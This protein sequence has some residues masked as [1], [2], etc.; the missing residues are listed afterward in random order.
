M[1]RENK[2]QAAPVDVEF[3]RSELESHWIPF[4]DNKSFKDDPRL[5]VKGEGVYLWNQR[6]ERLLDGSSGLFTTAAGHCRP[7]ITKA[8]A[9]QLAELDYIPS[10]LR[11]HPR[12]FELSNKLCPILP[13]PMNHVFFCNS[14]S[15]AVDSAIKIILQYHACRGEG[16]RNIFVSRHRAYHGVNIG[17][18]SLSGLVKNRTGFNGMMPGVV[19]MRSTW[20]EEQ[21]FSRG[22]PLHRGVELADDLLR[23]VQTHG[24]KSIAAVFVEPIAGSTGVLVPPVG[25]LERIREIC[26]EHNIIMVIDEVLTGFGRTGAAFASNAFGVVPDVMTMA[27]ALTNGAQPMGA[28]AVKDEI[29]ETVVNAS[30][31]DV[32]ELAHGYTYSAHPA[33]CAAAIATLEIYERENLFERA[34]K[35][36]EYFLDSVFAL[37]N[38]AAVTDIRGYGML[39]GFDVA[40]EG[41]VGIRGNRLQK[42]LFDA[43]LHIKTTGDAGIIAPPLTI[44]KEQ[45]DEMCEILKQ[46]LNRL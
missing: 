30:P 7:E 44:E 14:G 27:K 41:T 43:G 4:T 29:Y 5:V 21:C 42:R 25:Y 3:I 40:P 36:S 13:E 17:G 24:A 11:S 38:L 19:H 33:A 2:L 9:D 20:D 32:V 31:R 46:E 1:N 8:V 10:F 28:V 16:Q 34:R 45:I 15:E 18:T 26:D 35:I 23:V 22:Q 39:A 6:G 37:Q 12:A